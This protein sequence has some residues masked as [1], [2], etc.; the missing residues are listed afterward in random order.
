MKCI[1][2]SFMKSK[3]I[4]LRSN[5]NII[6]KHARKMKVI[7][8]MP[9]LG[10]KA[11]EIYMNNKCSRAKNEVIS[12]NEATIQ[13][14]NKWFKKVWKGRGE[15]KNNNYAFVTTRQTYVRIWSFK[16]SIFLS[17]CPYATWNHWSDSGS[18]VMAKCLHNQ[19]V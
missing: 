15:E 17:Q 8:D 1:V 2:C 12:F 3:D 5:F 7:C 16:T 18:W 19:I 10:K 11:S 9:H 14:Q 4:I 13:L 6:E